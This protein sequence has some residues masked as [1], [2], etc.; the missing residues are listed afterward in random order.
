VAEFEFQYR[1]IRPSNED[2]KF[3]R[4]RMDRYRRN[5]ARHTALR[6]L[7]VEPS[8]YSNYYHCET[9]DI[10]WEEAWDIYDQETT[11]MNCRSL[12]SPYDSRELYPEE[13]QPQT[14]ETETDNEWK[15]HDEHG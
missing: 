6:A 7:G 13:D 4:E 9:C 1:K 2:A 8:G 10:D 5:V 14:N 11:C 12:I 15:E 3:K